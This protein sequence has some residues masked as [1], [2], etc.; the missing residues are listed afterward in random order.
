M[1]VAVRLGAVDWITHNGDHLRSGW[2]KDET[3]ISK[4]T[5]KN[6]RLLWKVTLDNQSKSVYSIIG[7]PLV[8]QRLITD[9]GFKELVYVAGSSDNLYAVDA[10]L[11]KLFWK[12][13]FDY[14]AE[15]PQNQNSTFL[16]PGGLTAG[17][18]MSPRRGGAGGGIASRTMYLATSDGMLHQINAANGEDA[19]PP[20]PFMPP[21]GKPYSL[22]YLNDV[23]YT[24]TG[25]GC[26]G[27]LNSVYSIDLGDPAKTVRFWRSGGGGLW[28]TAGAAIGEDGTIFA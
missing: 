19:V 3:T 24:I 5:V 14:T 21:N 2:Q 26:G 10:D 11:G 8:V 15:I 12:R 17:P 4:E 28:G 27:N 18:A 16:C 22:A 7:S 23:I 25:Q 13:H 20:L 1:A 6:L 9:R